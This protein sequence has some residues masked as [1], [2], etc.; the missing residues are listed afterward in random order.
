MVRV[1]GSRNSVNT[2]SKSRRSPANSGRDKRLTTLSRFHCSET[3]R[4][5]S[6]R[7]SSK[8]FLSR[9]SERNLSNSRIGPLLKLSEGCPLNKVDNH[10]RIKVDNFRL[11]PGFG[12]VGQIGKDKTH[13]AYFLFFSE[14]FNK[15]PRFKI[16]PDNKVVNNNLLAY[17]LENKMRASQ[18][19]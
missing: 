2:P 8:S 19:Y 14:K 16:P 18:K 1:S 11:I 9:L 12:L 4:C 3:I 6:A 10:L 15:T 13:F 17:L 7:S 5:R